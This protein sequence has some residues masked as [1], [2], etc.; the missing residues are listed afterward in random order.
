MRPTKQI[1]LAKL[2]HQEVRTSVEMK[3]SGIL[4]SDQPGWETIEG[5]THVDLNPWAWTLDMNGKDYQ[6]E[7]FISE[8]NGSRNNG[9]PKLQG[10][11]SLT[12]TREE[13]G[14]FCA[15][16][17]FH[18]HLK[19]W[20]TLTKGTPYY[21]TSNLELIY[22]PDEDSLQG[23]LQKI[24]ARAGSLIVWSSE[25]PH[26][27][28]PNNSDRFRIN[29]YIKMFPAQEKAP[30]TTF[31]KIELHKYLG[32]FEPSPLGRKLFGLDTWNS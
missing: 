31:R 11:L 4:C 1:P 14:G 30:G 7:D 19:E 27:N 20:A 17:G 5:W 24:S 29:Q 3:P 9:E 26:C 28:F 22:I 23:M 10:V 21:D 2:P 8:N 25:L 16:P 18:K 32:G 15:V 13:D 12:N 6:F